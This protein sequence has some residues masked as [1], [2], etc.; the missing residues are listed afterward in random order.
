MDGL[1]VEIQVHLVQVGGSLTLLPATSREWY[2]LM[3]EKPPSDLKTIC[4]RFRI[5]RTCAGHA[6]KIGNLIQKMQQ[7]FRTYE[8]HVQP[9]EEMLRELGGIEIKS[10][11]WDYPKRCVFGTHMKATSLEAPRGKFTA[12]ITETPIIT[13]YL[14]LYLIARCLTMVLRHI[15]DYYNYLRAAYHDDWKMERESATWKYFEHHASIYRHFWRT[16]MINTEARISECDKTTELEQLCQMSVGPIASVFVTGV[17]SRA[18]RGASTE[19]LAS[20][21]K[22][23]D[24]K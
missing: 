5:G 14:E 6:I 16:V 19:H 9:S 17:V 15:E 8:D 12:I 7:P 23:F 2:H 13:T 21:C 10:T 22:Q 20:F 11:D 4:R 1:P 3:V 24:P 18:D